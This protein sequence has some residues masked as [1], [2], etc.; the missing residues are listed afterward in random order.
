MEP[1]TMFL[2]AVMCWMKIGEAGAYRWHTP[3]IGSGD[4]STLNREYFQQPLERST[5]PPIKKVGKGLFR[6]IFFIVLS[7]EIS[8]DLYN[9][10]VYH[11][12]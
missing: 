11:L 4:R 10:N 1:M 3:A 12:Q 9:L 7:R 8:G 6:I 5:A 2:S